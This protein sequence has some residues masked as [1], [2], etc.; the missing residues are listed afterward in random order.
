MPITAVPQGVELRKISAVQKRA[1]DELLS[2]QRENNLL[3]TTISTAIPALA[4]VGVGGA[5]LVVAWSYL[6]DLELPTAKDVAK[7]VTVAA[8]DVVSDVVVDVGGAVAKAAGFENDPKTPEYISI[9]GTMKGPLSRCKRWELDAQDWY[10]KTYLSG[11]LSKA[12]TVQAA[13]A[14][15]IIIKAMKAEGCSK[16]TSFSQTQWNEA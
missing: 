16:P 9:A 15:K 6:K 7:A 14:A 4:F 2:K 10:E 8:G 5:A 11:D 3:E 13:L 1:L 12:E